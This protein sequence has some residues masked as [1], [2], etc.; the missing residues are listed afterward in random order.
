M[1]L[2]GPLAIIQTKQDSNCISRGRIPFQ[3]SGSQFGESPP[4]PTYPPRLRI[5]SIHKEGCSCICPMDQK[6]GFYGG[7]APLQ[8]SAH[9]N[10]KR[11]SSPPPPPPQA[12]VSTLH[13]WC[14]LGLQGCSYR[15]S[16]AE[17][18]NLSHFSSKD[19]AYQSLIRLIIKEY[20]P[21]CNLYMQD[22]T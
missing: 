6:R 15:I 18:L 7:A 17:W 16:S 3:R 5:I 12:G 22:L 4:R 1:V 20:S 8:N 13:Y 21:L 11:V 2:L 19:D 10:S 14:P 9:L